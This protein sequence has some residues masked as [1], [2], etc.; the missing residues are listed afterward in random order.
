MAYAG[1]PVVH[2]QLLL[3]PGDAATPPQ[4]IRLG[5]AAWWTWLE[6]AIAFS[7]RPPHSL[8]ALTVRKEKRRH[9]CYWYA[10]AKIDS[11]LHNA[12]L[13]HAQTLTP[14]RLNQVL[15]TL[16]E[17]SRQQRTALTGKGG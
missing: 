6:T 1:T 5:T 12:Y 9:G 14:D 11:K 4:R 7:Y 3:L 17:K 15:H 13:G 8:Y 16:L 2:N 10:Y